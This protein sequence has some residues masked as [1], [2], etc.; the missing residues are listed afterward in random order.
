MEEWKYGNKKIKHLVYEIPN[1]WWINWMVWR[2]AVLLTNKKPP[3]FLGEK[4]TP[5]PPLK[6]FKKRI[7]SNFIMRESENH[8]CL[9]FGS[10]EFEMKIWLWILI[11][12]FLC[13]QRE[14]NNSFSYPSAC[15]F[16]HCRNF[17]IYFVMGC[18]FSFSQFSAC[19]RTCA[20][21]SANDHLWDIF[22]LLRCE[23]STVGNGRSDS[24]SH[25][26]HL[27]NAMWSQ[28]RA[29]GRASVPV[30]RERRPIKSLGCLRDLD[31]S[32]F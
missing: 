14:P 16:C 22:F 8:S 32:S 23:P 24:P 26:E 21:Y 30:V 4:N 11:Q 10:V 9:S 3:S 6:W 12:Y 28:R 25:W 1:F 27:A 18:G 20:R 19:L 29:K 17:L 7:E 31:K 5:P 2:L 13:L 15:C